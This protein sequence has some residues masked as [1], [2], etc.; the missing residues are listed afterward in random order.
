MKKLGADNHQLKKVILKQ[1]SIWCGLPVV[2]AV[3]LSIVVLG[4]FLQSIVE[5]IIAYI[6][7]EVLLLQMLSTAG[8][9][10][11]LLLCYFVVTWIMFK[12][13]VTEK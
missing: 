11:G 8:I 10:F 9:L 2:T 4:Y 12:Y 13:S 7:V 6:G 5:Q 3:F 1:L